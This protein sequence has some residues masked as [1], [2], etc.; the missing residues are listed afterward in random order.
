MEHNKIKLILS[1]TPEFV[2]T[3]DTQEINL[4]QPLNDTERY[5]TIPNDVFDE[6]L[7]L[8]HTHKYYTVETSYRDLEYFT[9]GST[10]DTIILLGVEA[11]D[12]VNEYEILLL[13]AIISI[14]RDILNPNELERVLEIFWDA[15]Y[16]DT[17]IILEDELYD[18]A[19]LNG[20]TIQGL[21]PHATT[22]DVEQ[23]FI[24]DVLEPAGFIY[25]ETLSGLSGYID[26]QTIYF[27]GGI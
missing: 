9:N 5:R 24:S 4:V 16:L 25:V 13:Q 22:A 12:L 2:E 18:F 23:E 11:H 3:T 21:P 17:P 20:I 7:D 19:Y 27:L 6:V 14:C 15:H 8:L 10:I 26:P 1:D